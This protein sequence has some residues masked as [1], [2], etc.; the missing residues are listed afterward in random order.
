MHRCLAGAAAAAGA[1]ERLERDVITA[2]RLEDLDDA[3]NGDDQRDCLLVMRQQIWMEKE[4]VKR[5]WEKEARG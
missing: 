5:G 3:L 2:G 1:L 4:G